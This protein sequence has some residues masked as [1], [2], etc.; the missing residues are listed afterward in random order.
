MDKIPKNE[1]VDHLR[2][3][4]VKTDDENRSTKHEEVGLKFE[5]S[6]KERGKTR[7]P[8][9]LNDLMEESARGPFA[10]HHDHLTK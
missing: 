3:S 5:N 9:Q 1:E 8:P 10:M 2:E 4:G 6:T 7:T